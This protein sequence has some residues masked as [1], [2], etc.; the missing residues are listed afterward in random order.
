MTIPPGESYERQPEIATSGW[1]IVAGESKQDTISREIEPKKKEKR[2]M[3]LTESWLLAT[4]G[5]EDPEHVESHE[6]QNLGKAIAQYAVVVGGLF[7][8]LVA[9][10]ILL[11]NSHGA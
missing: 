9:V 3:N 2:G 11:V 7:V 8:V 10:L 5:P 1:S 4:G 6:T